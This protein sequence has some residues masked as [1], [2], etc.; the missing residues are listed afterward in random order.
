M[1]SLFPP[2]LRT[3]AVVKRW[4]TTRTFHKD[5]V[6]EHSF[7][8]A[9]YALQI[10]R[11]LEWRGPQA[12]LLFCALMHDHEEAIVGDIISPIQQSIKNVMGFDAGLNAIPF[13]NEQIKERL[14]LIET[15]I[16]V[17]QESQWGA[18]IKA[19]VKVADKV[20][21]C[22]FLI[23]EIRMGNAV[24]GRLYQNALENLA[25]AWSIMGEALEID[26]DRLPELWNAEIYPALQAHHSYG[27]TGIT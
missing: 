2:E 5:S 15:Q 20:E 19:I 17:V 12:D 6:A 21:A 26:E 9:Y 11:L 18:Q 13:I 14:P 3:L 22:L 8:T 23:G 24:L 1:N 10:A 25:V 16:A 4:S 7:F 27:S